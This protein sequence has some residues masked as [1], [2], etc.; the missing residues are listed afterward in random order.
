MPTDKFSFLFGYTTNG[1][2]E[3]RRLVAAAGGEDPLVV[4]EGAIL[5]AIRAVLPN[6]AHKR[7]NPR[8]GGEVTA[9]PL[10]ALS[11]L[12]GRMGVPAA[13]LGAICIAEWVHDPD[14]LLRLALQATKDG[15]A[16]EPE[17]TVLKTC[18][19]IDLHME[20]LSDLAPYTLTASDVRSVEPPSAEDDDSDDEV[21]RDVYE[22]LTAHT[23]AVG[24]PLGQ[25]AS[26]GFFLTLPYRTESR[27][28]G[29]IE[30]IGGRE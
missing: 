3:R 15:L 14:T 17:E 19:K 5:A 2:A 13:D 12:I 10:S 16:W 6:M 22:V 24:R 11:L 1:G 8:G 9:F 29:E 20:G 27:E 18:T 28:K 30:R 25:A 23:V 26:L 4:V 21:D 7:Q